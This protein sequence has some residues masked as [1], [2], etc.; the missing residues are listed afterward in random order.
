MGLPGASFYVRIDKVLLQLSGIPISP[1]ERLTKK[2]II[3]S[4]VCIT[5]HVSVITL[6]LYQFLSSLGPMAEVI[7]MF[8]G[9]PWVFYNAMA[10]W[11]T[12]TMVKTRRD[13]LVLFTKL[14]GLQ[15][16]LESS[17]MQQRQCVLLPLVKV[18]LTTLQS[19]RSLN[20]YLLTNLTT[21]EA[22][23]NGD[24]PRCLAMVLSVAA[25]INVLPSVALFTFITNGY[26]TD[27]LF[28]FETTEEI[29]QRMCFRRNRDNLISMLP[30]V[31]TVTTSSSS[32]V[33]L[34]HGRTQL[35]RRIGSYWETLKA[36]SEVKSIR[37]L[38]NSWYHIPVTWLTFS[39]ALLA[40]SLLFANSLFE[41]N[42]L[43]ITRKIG[44]FL[45]MVPCV[46]EVIFLI[47]ASDIFINDGRYKSVTK[48]T[49]QIFTSTDWQQKNILSRF[50]FSS[51][52]EYPES[53]YCT[54]QSD[55]FHDQCMVP[56]TLLYGLATPLMFPSAVARL[57]R[58]TNRQ[59]YVDECRP[60]RIV[61]YIL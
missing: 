18:V 57:S 41:T 44:M 9:A 52:D 4:T 33:N 22:F 8:S 25:A 56:H 2:Q 27:S 11:V 58:K 7:R 42:S 49:K 23:E 59:S 3:L 19:A 10:I 17:M 16:A 5:S 53:S 48:A 29:V 45:V 13:A 51:K 54:P 28:L 35:D 46:V 20:Q 24:L 30:A 61:T 34:E 55:T 43:T 14:E 12:L 15:K 21:L 26:I 32:E 40:P 47:F 37:L 1:R 50:V 36:H 6:V 38:H 60:T 31:E 39:F